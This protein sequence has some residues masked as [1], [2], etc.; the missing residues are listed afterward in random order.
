MLKYELCFREQFTKQINTLNEPYF[1]LIKKEIFSLRDNYF[2]PGKKCK[3]MQ[4][5]IRNLYRL[6]I[7]SW[8]VIYHVDHTKKIITIYRLFQRGEGYNLTGF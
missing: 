4:S 7:G 1:S 6:R 2:P 5:K 3:R 8:R